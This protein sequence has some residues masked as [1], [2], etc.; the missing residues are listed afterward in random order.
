MQ[1]LLL[2]S[3][4][5]V[6]ATIALVLVPGAGAASRAELLADRFTSAEAPLVFPKRAG[7]VPGEQVRGVPPERL[8]QRQVR[9]LIDAAAIRLGI[10]ARVIDRVRPGLVR[11][12]IGES[13]LR[14]GLVQQQMDANGAYPNRARGLF[15]VVP[16]LFR[17]ARVPGHDNIFNP[18]DNVLAAMLVFWTT[19]SRRGEFAST[20]GD[21]VDSCGRRVEARRRP[22]CALPGIWPQST[23]WSALRFTPARNPY[24]TDAQRRFADRH[25]PW[26]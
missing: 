4:I 22:R 2:S 9:L 10:P 15:Q 24:L 20:R 5:A 26:R 8:T 19:P 12:A 17:G 25:S 23:G 16:G 6:C 14:P 7:R 18:Y 21:H 1:R 11:T 3:T 13:D